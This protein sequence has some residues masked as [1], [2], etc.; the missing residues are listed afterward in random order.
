MLGRML[1]PEHAEMMMHRGGGHMGDHMGE[2][3]GDE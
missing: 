3:G 1:M 2:G